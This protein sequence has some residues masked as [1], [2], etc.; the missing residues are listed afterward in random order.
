MI[1][2]AF[3]CL[4]RGGFDIETLP[5]LERFY[6]DTLIIGNTKLEGKPNRL[7]GNLVENM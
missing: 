4:E 2:P 6:G 7:V 3:V 1:S 5:S